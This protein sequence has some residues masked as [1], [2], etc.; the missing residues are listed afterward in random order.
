MELTERQLGEERQKLHLATAT[1]QKGVNQTVLEVE[2]EVRGAQ[3]MARLA[4][5]QK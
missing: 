3:D 2:G 1:E 4:A 5:Q